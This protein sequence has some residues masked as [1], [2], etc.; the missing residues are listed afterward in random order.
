MNLLKRTDSVQKGPIMPNVILRLPAVKSRTGLSR[1]TIYL[2]ISRDKFPKSVS[3]GE[4]AV[5]FV[6]SEIDA[7][8]AQR[9]TTSRIRQ[10][11][12]R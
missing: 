6:E 10:Q 1:S 12:E 8:I 7:W 11:G 9:I 4:R 3:L 2:L 5:G